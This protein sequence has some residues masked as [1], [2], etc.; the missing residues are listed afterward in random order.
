MVAGCHESLRGLAN[1]R[2]FHVNS[3]L[4]LA[5]LNAIP[6]G[7]SYPANPEHR[8]LVGVDLEGHM[9]DAAVPL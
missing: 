8:G 9:E 5:P 7:D 2:G 4:E 1:R 3:Y 6:L